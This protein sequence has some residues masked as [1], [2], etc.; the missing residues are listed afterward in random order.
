LRK[1]SDRTEEFKK[2]RNL[3]ENENDCQMKRA[4]GPWRRVQRIEEKSR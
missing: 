1:K 4:L 3:F 2:F